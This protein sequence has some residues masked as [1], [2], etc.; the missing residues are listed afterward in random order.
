MTKTKVAIIGSGPS[1]YSAAI[2][3]SRA[4]LEPVL[5]TGLESGGQLMYTNELE[6]F[7]GFPEGIIGAQF[8]MNLRKQ[9]ERFGTK[10]FNQY[11]TAVDF[12]SKNFKLWTALP[13]GVSL[14]DYQKKSTQEIKIL[15]EQI[16]QLEPTLQSEAVLVAT[17]A[18]AIT[19]GI[20][21]EEKFFGRGVSV[22][23]VCDSAFYKDKSV[24]VVGGGDSAMEDTL[25]LTRFVNKVTIVHR[26]D[27]FRASKIMQQRVLNNP[28]VSVL[29]N[30]QLKEIIG[31]QLVQAVVVDVAGKQQQLASDGVFLAIGHK[32]ASNLFA[33]QLATTDQGYILTRRSSNQAGLAMAQSALDAEGKVQFPTMT[34]V[35]GVFSAGD[36]VDFR[37]RQAITAAGM[38]AEASLDIEKWLEK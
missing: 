15:Q 21:G 31:E 16:R 19:L 7:P 30:A 18:K 1:A 26:R 3:L 34:S 35:E 28:K 13:E 2:Y 6:N 4:Q 36:V 29:W 23:A 37:Y 38:G 22:C 14:Q 12:S 8:M 11:I 20:P 9:A 27:Q 33:S 25:A 24:V 10:I 32:P 5:F 17:G